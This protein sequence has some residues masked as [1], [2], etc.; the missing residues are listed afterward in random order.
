MAVAGFRMEHSNTVNYGMNV[1]SNTIWLIG[2]E[3][4]KKRE[5]KLTWN[6][7]IAL[8][9][10]DSQRQRPSC[11]Q[12]FVSVVP[13]IGQLVSVGAMAGHTSAV[14]NRYQHPNKK[15]STL[16]ASPKIN[17]YF[18]I[19]FRD[20]NLFFIHI[21]QTSISYNSS[22]TSTAKS[23][24]IDPEADRT[25]KAGQTRNTPGSINLGHQ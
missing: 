7:G 5:L 20:L 12:V 1:V 25:C 9:E 6:Y 23:R 16:R 14:T 21:F 17:D 4:Q 13:R 24:L 11:Q 3:G 10:L 22:S 15:R 18:R 2:R 8:K 19:F